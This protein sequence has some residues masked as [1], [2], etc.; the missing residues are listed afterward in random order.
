MHVQHLMCKNRLVDSRVSIIPIN[1]PDIFCSLGNCDRRGNILP[2]L[3]SYNYR[4]I[5]QN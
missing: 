2:W 3:Y 5:I 4:E 1:T